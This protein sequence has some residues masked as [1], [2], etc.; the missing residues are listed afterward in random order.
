MNRFIAVNGEL[1]APAWKLVSRHDEPVHRESTLERHGA[2]IRPPAR[3]RSV[4]DACGLQ[5][6]GRVSGATRKQS[7]S[8]KIHLTRRTSC[9]EADV[10]VDWSSQGAD[11]FEKLREDV[12]AGEGDPAAGDDPFD[13]S[14]LIQRHETGSG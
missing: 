13:P 5:G 7:K 8:N 4:T 10:A 9:L 12:V 11:V 14:D 3:G 6:Q 1:H 2:N